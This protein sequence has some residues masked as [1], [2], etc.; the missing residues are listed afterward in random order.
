MGTPVCSP[1]EALSLVGAVA[2]VGAGSAAEATVEPPPP[3]H[4]CGCGCG[5]A[6]LPKTC[7]LASQSERTGAPGELSVEP[8]KATTASRRSEG[9]GA[10]YR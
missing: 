6:L 4:G 9:E 3:H 8:L 7:R 10:R 2:S 5:C 1:D